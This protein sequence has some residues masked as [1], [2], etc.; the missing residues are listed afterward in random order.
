MACALQSKK[1]GGARPLT[2]WAHQWGRSV[3]G[4]G[5]CV[6]GV[7]VG[8][9][10]L[11][12]EGSGGRSFGQMVDPAQLHDD[13]KWATGWPGTLYSPHVSGISAATGSDS[14]FRRLQ[15]GKVSSM[16]C[17]SM[18]FPKKKHLGPC[19]MKFLGARC[20]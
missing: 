14:R 7:V 12:G 5:V 17:G 1:K 8:V 10:R 15:K 11:T 20:W 2:S 19:D 4:C 3:S 13:D 16:T 6:V 18:D 9:Y